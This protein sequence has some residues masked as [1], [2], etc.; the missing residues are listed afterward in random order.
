MGRMGTFTGWGCLKAK[1]RYHLLASLRQLG[2]IKT[3]ARVIIA[4]EIQVPHRYFRVQPV[5]DRGWLKL[6][7]TCLLCG[8]VLKGN[9]SEG[10][11]DQMREHIS[12]SHPENLKA[13]GTV[14]N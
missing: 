6:E 9:I 10:I 3:N 14:E 2:W 4:P 7:F 11:E 5:D 8:F 12:H 13:L 1:C